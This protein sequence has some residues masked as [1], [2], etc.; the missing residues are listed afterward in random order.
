VRLGRVAERARRRVAGAAEAERPQ[1]PADAA[2]LR[3][4]G[5]PLLRVALAAVFG[6]A[7]ERAL[8]QIALHA[9]RSF[10]VV[11]RAAW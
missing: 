9:N 11:G 5:L 4:V 3:E 1:Q 7:L 8:Q 10:S 6:E 2:E